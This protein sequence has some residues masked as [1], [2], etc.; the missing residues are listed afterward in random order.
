[1]A[2]YLY[3][4]TAADVTALVVA[5]ANDTITATVTQASNLGGS[6]SATNIRFAAAKIGV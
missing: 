5:A 6:R 3:G 1:M 2:R 4:G